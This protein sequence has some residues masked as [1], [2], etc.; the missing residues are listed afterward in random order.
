ME[1]FAG[2]TAVVTGAASGIGRATALLL[3]QEGAIVIA[4]DINAEGVNS[5]CATIEASGGQALPWEVDV[6]RRDHVEAFTQAVVDRFGRIDVLMN[7]AGI[8]RRA[9]F[10]DFDEAVWDRIMDVNLKGVLHLSRTVARH[11]VERGYGRIVSIASTAGEV[12]YPHLAPA[13]HVSKAGII[14]LTRY[15]AQ[16]LAPHGVT[17]NAIG[18][19]IIA[20]PNT[21]PSISDPE[22]VKTAMARIPMKRWGQPEDVAYV[23]LFLA[24]DHAAYVTGQTLFVDGGMLTLF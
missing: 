23:A 5:T 17:V 11:M 4:G 2:R 15:M 20:T 19:G 3:A 9:N 6:A 10:I 18:P 7:I 22:Y 8:A 16:E 12:V 1:R 13:Y 21:E 24:S 14:Q